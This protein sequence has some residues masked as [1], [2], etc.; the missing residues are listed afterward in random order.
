MIATVG[1]LF[2]RKWLEAP[3]TE[4]VAAGWARLD[5]LRSAAARF[6]VELL[7]DDYLHLL[8]PLWSAR[9][10]RGRVRGVRSETADTTTVT[11][12]PGRGFDFTFRP[13]QCIGIGVL[14]DG[15]WRWRSYSLTRPPVWSDP[16][17]TGTQV[18]SITVTALPEGRTADHLTGGVVGAIVRLATPPDTFLLP[19]PPPQHVLF[20]TAGSAITPMI[21]MLRTMDRRGRVPDVVHVHFTRTAADTKYTAELV[22]LHDRH[23]SFVGL[24][25]RTA[26]DGTFELSTLGDAV[27]DW[28]TRHTWVRGPAGLLDEVQRYWERAGLADRLHVE[29]FDVDHGVSTEGGD[30]MFTRSGRSASADGAT[31]LLEAGE[32]AGVPMPYGCRIGICRTCALTLTKGIT[33]DLRN[34]NESRAG[35]KIQTCV[36]TAAGDCAVE[37]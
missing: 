15:R 36:S 19:E 37:I 12:E 2:V 25:H 21:S 11:I 32:D 9:E 10:L 1:G 4:I 27:P 7:P 14:S 13:G 6:T 30:V 18:I 28:R 29:R 3:V 20:L 26:A 34:G 8:D 22:A 31:T 35:E 24:A 33:L 16:E 23:P 17:N 5:T